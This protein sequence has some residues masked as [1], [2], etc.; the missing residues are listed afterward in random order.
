M[1]IIFIV[2]AAFILII[3]AV[4][5][6]HK[7]FN[8]G[9]AVGIFFG[10]ALLT[11]GVLWQR[12][13]PNVQLYLSIFICFILLV[14]IVF[15]SS[16]YNA[17]RSNA[18]DQ[19]VIIVL[20]CRVKGDKPSRALLGR[21][22]AAYRYLAVNPDAVAILSGGQGK[23]EDISEAECIRRILYDRG[24]LNNRLI[25]E[26]KSTS[27]DENIRFSLELM[28]KLGLDTQNAAIATSEY[29]QKRAQIICAGYGIAAKAQSSRTMPI[30]LPTFLLREVFGLIKAYFTV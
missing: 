10:A 22:D 4:P 18:S 8:F 19:Q 27:T 21:A 17:G 1:Q 26:D 15:M 29:H 28:K 9:N 24:I 25:L 13:E 16:I 20:G 5:I 30:L 23:D 2:L 7:V 6:F 14:M 12:F 3:F 11:I